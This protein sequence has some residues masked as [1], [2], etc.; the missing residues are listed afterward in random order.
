MGAFQ[1]ANLY[2]PN[3][4]EMEKV[5]FRRMLKGYLDNMIKTA[6]H[7]PVDEGVHIE[8][9][10]QI[11]RYAEVHKDILKNGKL[12]FGI[13]QKLLNLY[14][15]YHWCMGLIPTLPHFPVD[16]I[17]QKKL[18]LKVIAWTKMSNDNDY[19]T[20]IDSAKKNLKKN[21]CDSLAELELLLFERNN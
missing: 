13:S 4:P 7:S 15:K 12:N 6:Y 14:L 21:N 16:S 17:I 9:I 2:K 10:K 19:R 20:I 3:T 18:N 11:S 8:N 1:R 5:Y